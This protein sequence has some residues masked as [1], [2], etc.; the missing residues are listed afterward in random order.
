MARISLRQIDALLNGELEPEEASRLREAIE[1]SPVAKGYLERQQGLRPGPDWER[2]RLALERRR[3]GRMG[4]ARD[5]GLAWFRA[6]M[7]RVN[8]VHGVRV[9]MGIAG[10]AVLILVPALWWAHAPA[11]RG[12]DRLT[13]KGSG[14]AEMRL[15]IHG[16]DFA[17]GTAIPASPG[18]TLGFT[19][20]SADTLNVQAWYREDDGDTLSFAGRDAA[21]FALPP[22]T[23]WTPAPETI[24][25]EG[26]WRRQEVWLVLSRE[27]LDAARA[28][29]A[30]R[31]GRATDGIRVLAFRL[32]RA[33]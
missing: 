8:A 22:V 13:A 2:M 27:P 4:A 30:L 24:R 7:P 33:P 12:G 19:Y 6:A 21:G 18:D 5:L 25:L 10:L 1:G 9:A 32:A 26:E 14:T 15:E 11:D 23:A 28:R 31:A 17:A 16:R 29:E 20:R 3:A